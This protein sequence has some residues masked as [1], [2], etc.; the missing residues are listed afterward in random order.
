MISLPHWQKL[1]RPAQKQSWFC[2][3]NQTHPH[4]IVQL[5][6]VLFIV[7]RNITCQDPKP[8]WC[9]MGSEWCWDAARFPPRWMGAEDI[10]HN[11][12]RHPTPRLDVFKILSEAWCALESLVDRVHYG[13]TQACSAGIWSQERC[14]TTLV[15]N[16]PV[17]VK[18]CWVWVCYFRLGTLLPSS[19][20][21][22]SAQ[23]DSPGSFSLHRAAVRASSHQQ[24]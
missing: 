24:V 1:C 20:A 21:F 2:P 4:L 13:Q 19:P 9:N 8:L 23:R 12:G 10:Q 22:S 11:L 15:R 17:L 6:N 18:P 16:Q 3:G 5:N 14:V 7:Y